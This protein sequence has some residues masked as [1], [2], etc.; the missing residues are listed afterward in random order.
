MGGLL[1]TQPYKAESKLGLQPI[2]IITTPE[3]R[4]LFTR[5]SVGFLFNVA[6]C[7]FYN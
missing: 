5:V 7:C 3:S 4:A 1:S 2:H 6:A